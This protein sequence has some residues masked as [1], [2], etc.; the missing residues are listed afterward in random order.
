MYKVELRWAAH[1][2]R[3]FDCE[4]AALPTF[5]GYWQGL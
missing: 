1:I 3:S 5:L 2:L 4:R